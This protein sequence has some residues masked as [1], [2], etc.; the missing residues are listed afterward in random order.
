MQSI[1]FARNKFCSTSIAG[2]GVVGYIKR[3]KQAN[4]KERFAPVMF[5]CF[6]RVVIE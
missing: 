5:V 1:S 6:L 2:N 3:N 4:K